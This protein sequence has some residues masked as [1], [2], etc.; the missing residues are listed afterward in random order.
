[1]IAELD[2]GIKFNGQDKAVA[3]CSRATRLQGES[4]FNAKKIYSALPVTIC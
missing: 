4:G 3:I 2:N 1:M